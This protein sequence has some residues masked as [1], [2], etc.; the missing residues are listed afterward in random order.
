MPKA[1]PDPALIASVVIGPT[2]TA[3]TITIMVMSN[4]GPQIPCPPNQSEMVIEDSKTGMP[5]SPKRRHKYSYSQQYG[6]FDF[7]I[8]LFH[9][10][11]LIRFNSVRQFIVPSFMRLI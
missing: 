1:S 3:I 7:L 2:T 6:L 11:L 9:D 10:Y 8:C 4:A 5:S